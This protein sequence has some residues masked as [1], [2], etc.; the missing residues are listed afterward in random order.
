MRL[1][2]AIIGAL[3]FYSAVR[4]SAHHP[5]FPEA[6]QTQDIA[7]AT[8][9]KQTCLCG[10]VAPP[11]PPLARLS[12]TQGVVRVNMSLDS[13][14][15]PT[16][17]QVLPEESLQAPQMGILQQAA[18][19]AARKWRFCSSGRQANSMI[20]TFKFQ[21]KVDPEIS[22]ADQ[23]SPTEVRFETPDTVEIKTTV[24]SIRAE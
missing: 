4:H 21:L 16:E 17:A 7:P 15:T 12:R 6:A 20:V 14:G 23:W 1:S 3:V 10:F 11:Y 9:A 22:N 19:E 18:L 2:S 24:T 13:E 5:S 8:G